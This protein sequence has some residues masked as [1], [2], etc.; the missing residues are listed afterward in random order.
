MKN[1]L[2][3]LI[4]GLVA[5]CT[6]VGAAAVLAVGWSDEQA[7]VASQQVTDR[8]LL[9]TRWQAE[10][11]VSND[12]ALSA[13]MNT[14]P[15][16]Q[17]VLDQRVQTS[18]AQLAKL[19]ESLGQTQR[20]P[21][22]QASLALVLQ[23]GREIGQ[24]IGKLQAMKQSG[25]L[26]RAVLGVSKELKP[27]VDE[28]LKAMDAHLSR[29]EQGAREQALAFEQQRHRIEMLALALAALAIGLG[30]V[31]A[32][33]V[34]RRIAAAITVCLNTAQAIASGDLTRPA[35]SERND[36]LG[37]LVRALETM[38]ST[39]SSTLHTIQQSGSLVASASN[40]IASGNQDLQRRTEDSAAHLQ[41]TA[42]AMAHL[43]Q[44]LS[45]SA[46]SAAS[47]H[48]LATQATQAA[49]RG[50]QVVGQV[51]ATMDTISEASRRITDI[52]G[53]IDGIAFQTN[54]LALN[55]AVEAARAGEQGRG[56]AVVASEVRTLAQ[57]SASAAREIKGLITSNVERV[58]AGTLQVKDASAAMDEIVACVHRVSQTISEI[59]ATT[60]EQSQGITGVNTGLGQLDAMTRDNAHLVD[61]ATQA[62]DSLQQEAHHLAGAVS[63]F[64][65]SAQS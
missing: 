50:G 24:L 43:Q 11:R 54:I 38:R 47:A 7:R 37:D 42:E 23:Q 12:A 36:E 60:A 6:L 8:L 10:V 19:V 35:H 20:S 61:E 17:G 41:S 1:Q 52:V 33:S 28:Q 29:V 44:G 34:G 39:L 3:A 65:L 59:S 14:N 55:A 9:T 57:R 46:A 32:L 58:E 64:H 27:K 21:E 4:L 13:I 63:R 25:E 49:G 5:G 53:V 18:S 45:H 26:A 30:F 48:Q 15:V 40:H 56:F 62:A 16:A 2:F 31:V 22:E 51:T